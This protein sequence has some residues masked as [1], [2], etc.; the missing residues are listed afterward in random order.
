MNPEQEKLLEEFE[1]F[2]CDL[3][4]EEILKKVKRTV[5]KTSV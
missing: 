4:V 2:E 3:E 1:S 5:S